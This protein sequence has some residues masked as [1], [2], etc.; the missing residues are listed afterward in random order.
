[1]P[2]GRNARWRWPRR[3][4]GPAMAVVV[5][6][7]GLGKRYG[8]VAAVEDVDLR[9][10]AGDIYALLGL[11]G[12]G[13]T[14]TIRMLLGMACPTTGSVTLFGTPVGPAQRRLWARVGYL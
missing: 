3:R 4:G 7:V 2:D 5:R 6:A 11:N 13:K 14:T 9:V 8:P 12:A 10:D 1:N